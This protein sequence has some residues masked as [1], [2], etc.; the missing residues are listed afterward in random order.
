MING[1]HTQQPPPGLVP[2]PGV[3][4]KGW[5]ASLVP[6]TGRVYSAVSFIIG[7]QVQKA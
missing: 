7:F 5:F 2:G 4:C 6:C 1:E 3:W